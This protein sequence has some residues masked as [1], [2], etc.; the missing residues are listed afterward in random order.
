MPVNHVKTKQPGEQLALLT[1]TYLQQIYT[2]YMDDHGWTPYLAP[3]TTGLTYDPNGSH[4][5]DQTSM[6]EITYPIHGYSNLSTGIY[7]ILPSNEF[8]HALL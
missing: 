8:R 2:L 4:P 6:S 1:S 7:W 3:G 5:R